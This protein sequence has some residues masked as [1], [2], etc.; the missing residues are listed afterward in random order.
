MRTVPQKRGWQAVLKKLLEHGL[1]VTLARPEESGKRYEVILSRTAAEYIPIGLEVEAD[2]RRAKIESVDFDKNIVRLKLLDTNY[3][4][5]LEPVA[6]VRELVEEA[7]DRNIERDMAAMLTEFTV[8]NGPE[9]VQPQPEQAPTVRELYD[10]Y[11]SVLL[12]KL[13]EDEAYRNACQNSD[14]QNAVDEGRNAVERAA[15][16]LGITQGDMQFYQLYFGDTAFHNRLKDELVEESY[17]LMSE[18]VLPAQE[19]ARYAPKDVP[20]IFCE[21]SESDVF[22]DKTAYSLAEFDRLMKERDSAY[23][24][25]REEGVE[26]YGSWQEM[27]DSDDPEYVPYL[28]YEKVKFT[29]VMPDGRTFSERQDIGDGDGGVV[30]FLGKYD[31][32]QDILPQLQE[33]LGQYRDPLAPAYKVGDTVYLD[34][35]AFTITN[36]GLFDV[37]LRDPTLTYSVLRSEKNLTL[38][39]CFAGMKEICPLRTT[40]QL[41]KSALPI[42]ATTFGM[43]SPAR[44][45][46]WMCRQKMRLQAGCK[47]ASVTRKAPATWVKNMKAPLKP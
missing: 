39:S 22:Q 29:L 18:K 44:V 5:L 24:E 32:Y 47:M 46:C 38:K 8:E 21:W 2:G 34:N 7:N 27:Y 45:D 20:Y 35:T 10:H 28:G 42:T 4:H 17:L 31:E 40:S 6:Y 14:R 36:V 41:R 19:G 3:S 25:K 15:K 13:M 26:K 12:P 33:T 37:Q 23:I 11:K 1:D 9:P 30:D 16:D 43:F